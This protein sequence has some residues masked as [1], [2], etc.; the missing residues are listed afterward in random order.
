M[1]H[2]H[3]LINKRLRVFLASSQWNRPGFWQCYM[4]DGWWSGQGLR[5]LQ[6]KHPEGNFPIIRKSKLTRNHQNDEQKHH[7]RYWPDCRMIGGREDDHVVGGR[8]SARQT[9]GAGQQVRTTRPNASHSFHSSVSASQPPPFKLTSTS[10]TRS[11]FHQQPQQPQLQPI[12]TTT[13]DFNQ[14]IKFTDDRKYA[15]QG[16]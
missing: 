8:E 1:G 6:F 14:A 7:W 15:R 5:Q 16:W 2:H 13:I 3:K 11:S 4:P 9:I 10:P 12:I